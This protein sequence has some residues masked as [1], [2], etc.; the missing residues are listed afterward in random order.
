MSTPE[1]TQQYIL[2]QVKQRPGIRHSALLGSDRE[3]ADRRR[4]ALSLL[5]AQG[6]IEKTKTRPWTYRF[7]EPT[8]AND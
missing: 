8:Y 7:K 4:D 6:R 5:I 1:Q 2:Q 3:G